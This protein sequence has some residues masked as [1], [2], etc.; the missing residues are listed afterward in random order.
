MREGS[1]LNI[2][3]IGGGLQGTEITCLARE[4]GFKTV[5]FDRRKRPPARGLCH[6]FH[7]LEINRQNLDV[8]F[9]LL[10][11][12]EAVLP[13]LED[14]KVL[15]LLDRGC[16]RENLPFIFD[17]QAFE[18]TSCKETSRRFFR[19][20]NLPH[21]RQPP[22][23]DFPLILKPARGSGSSGVIK[24]EDQAELEYQRD[25]LSDDDDV[26]VEEYLE[27]P[28][29]SLEVLGLNGSFYPLM[30]TRLE[31]DESFDCCRVLAGKV[32]TDRRQNELYELAR[33]IA[34][35]LNL[36]GIMDIEIILTDSGCKIMEI[37]ARF[38]SQTPLAVYQASG[39]NMVSLLLSG[40]KNK[41]NKDLN[42]PEL[43]FEQGAAV[44]EQMLIKKSEGETKIYAPVGEH[45]LTEGGELNIQRN[46]YGADLA[47]TDLPRAHIATGENILSTESE[48][49]AEQSWR[50]A[51]VYTGEDLKEAR[52]K[53]RRSR[54]R[55]KNGLV[56]ERG[57]PSDDQA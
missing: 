32:I 45:V 54:N 5:L 1:R 43:S 31:F 37:D 23:A 49:K 35:A 19:R 56:F 26:L 52:E 53:S 12:V 10:P 57:G 28:A 47:L 9:D 7:Q 22:A 4:A 40:A 29:F 11:E 44:L 15:K 27:G 48:A 30:P 3:V 55:L 16:R 51:L 2:A 33:R 25:Q 18:I 20:H 21:A 38:P 50:A 41:K 42:L 39:L 13:A 46:F 24:V 14:Y 34:R 17:L 6:D 36:E 8:F